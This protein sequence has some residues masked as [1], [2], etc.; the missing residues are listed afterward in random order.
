MRMLM[1]SRDSSRSW[2]DDRPRTMTDPARPAFTFRATITATETRKSIYAAGNSIA[3]QAAG[4]G[5]ARERP[6]QGSAQ[7]I[8][9]ES[10]N[11]IRRRAPWAA[12]A[13][14]WHATGTMWK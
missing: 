6:R 2:Q 11:F 8:R 10:R 4:W 9:K 5:P 1:M 7:H 12:I 14:V 3:E 13:R